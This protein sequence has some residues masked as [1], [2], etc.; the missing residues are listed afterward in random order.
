M[1]KIQQ[2]IELYLEK[3]KINNPE[4]I[5]LV[6]FSGGY[7]SMCLLDCL[8]KITPNRIIALHLNHNW[9]GNESDL[10]EENCK[11]F[12]KKIGVEIYTEKLPENIPHTETA[13]REARYEFFE[14]CAKKFNS[15]IIFT[16]H[17]KNDNAETLLY[18]I[19]KG[20]GISGL[21]GISEN[22]GIYYRP[23]LEI[24]REEIE[25]YCKI[26]NLVPN[27]DSSNHNIKYKRNFIRSEI[28]PQL[29]KINP[30]L[31]D[32]IETLSTVAREET[33]IIEEYLQNIL[34]KI[35][36]DGKIKTSEFLKQSDAVQ[37]RIVYNLFINNNL[38][39]DRTKILKILDFI[40]ESSNSKSGKTCSLTT[41][42][43]IF[44]S[45][46]FIEIIN[47]C[48]KDFPEFKIQS[49]GIYAK[50]NYI[51][52]LQ[53]CNCIVDKFPKDTKNCAYVDLTDIAI[54]FEIRTRKDGDIIQP[55]GLSGSQKLKKYLNAKKIP[56][57]EKDKLLFLTS[58]KEV[59]W[60]IGIGISDKIKVTTKPTHIIK[61][62]KKEG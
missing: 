1:E 39:Y 9:R 44:T 59:L 45:E 28:I 60:A 10:E 16:A 31:L 57:H 23:I 54:D 12:C 13:G 11:H 36:K 20:T 41:N 52:E 27:D 48:K 43:W 8:K 18:R 50:A 24:T 61:F 2:K 22:R 21:Q 53:T 14:N 32:T 58:G 17:N 5:Y 62:Y 4:L 38:D 6:A 56:N 49:E 7:D 33:G 35:S 51:F 29:Q 30:N 42:L 26:N 3:Y 40:K 47:N 19:C 46:R 37:K 34:K 25:N 15:K 55:F